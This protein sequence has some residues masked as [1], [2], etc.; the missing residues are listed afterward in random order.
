MAV[1]QIP[2]PA[3]VSLGNLYQYFQSDPPLMIIHPILFFWPIL[4]AMTKT[5]L[6][7]FGDTRVLTVD[8]TNLPHALLLQPSGIW[9]STQ[10]DDT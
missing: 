10:A 7:A 6:I 8:F 5:T 2:R 3:G 9:V 4:S 1:F